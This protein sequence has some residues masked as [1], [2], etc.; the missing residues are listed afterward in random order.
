MTLSHRL[1]TKLLVTLCSVIALTL[2]L[3]VLVVSR[4]SSRVAEEEATQAATGL[5][6]DAAAQVHARFE[7]SVLTSRTIAQSLAALK[8]AGN[9]DRELGSAMVRRTVEET[10]EILGLWF[11]WEPNAF[12]G[13][14]AKFA[15]KGFVDATGR[16]MAWWNRG[17][18]NI[19]QE[20]AMDYEKPGPGDCYL[21]PR[22]TKKETLL[23]PYFYT[24]AGKTELI[25]GISVPILMDGK[26]MGVVGEDMPLRQTQALVATIKPFEKGFATLTSSQGNLIAHPNA[27]LLGK[28]LGDSAADALVKRALASRETQVGRVHSDVLGAEAIAVVVPFVVGHSETPWAL[29][30]FAPLETVLAPA[31]QLRT[32]TLAL[33]V[34]ALLALALMVLVVVRRV[35]RP[36]ERISEVATQIAAG[37]LTEQVEHRS[38]DEIGALAEAFRTMSERLAQVIGEVRNGASA[39]SS[40]SGQL[41]QTSQALSSGTSEQA[42]SFEEVTA[43]L[44]Q[45]RSSIDQNATHSA[46]VDTLALKGAN[47]AAESG[48]AVAELVEA[49]KQIAGR[50]TIIEDIAYQTNLLALNAAIEAARAG[51]HGRGFAVVASEVRKLAEGSQRA[52]RD[53]VELASQRVAQAERTGG[54]LEE[55]VPSIQQTSALVKEVA[56]AST[57]QSQSVG[58]M[59]RAVLGLNS[60]TQQNASAAEELAAT[61]EEMASHAQSLLQLM[62][63]FRTAE[64]AGSARPGGPV[65]HLPVRAQRPAVAPTPAP[66]PR[67]ESR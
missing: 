29:T 33:G 67:L 6:R 12:D 26:F 60:V 28:P 48:R 20:V 3:V 49:M 39:L 8:L 66:S 16:H 14:D 34:L 41:S 17:S 64:D 2:G 40:A 9:T 21:L 50:I 30:V 43:S 1:S 13:A 25:T 46:R 53:I 10:P 54:M 27:E 5:A 19:Q 51:E 37:N 22:A 44:E 65:V 47:D 7:R 59:N 56:A 15:N 18:G 24:T 35:T 55:L 32:F 36:L 38:S 45:M 11:I 61:A 31:H 58:Q 57:E 4:Q 62:S 52:A 23:E 63:F 42:A